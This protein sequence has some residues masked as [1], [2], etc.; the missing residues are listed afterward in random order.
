[1][2]VDTAVNTGI[3][4]ELLA[5]DDIHESCRC[6]CK[7][8]FEAL[9]VEYV[10]WVLSREIGIVLDADRVRRP[11]RQQVAVRHGKCCNHP[12]RSETPC[13][14]RDFLRENRERLNGRTEG[15]SVRIIDKSKDINR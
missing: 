6:V 3:N 14:H 1:M 10:G 9:T 12:A 11:G 5:I 7:C 13:M 8:A 2:T 4:V 15:T